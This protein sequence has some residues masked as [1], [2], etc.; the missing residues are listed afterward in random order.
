MELMG[1]NVLATP[2]SV[3]LSPTV[4]RR[5]APDAPHQ[6]QGT[7]RRCQEPRSHR[8]P[9]TAFSSILSALFPTATRIGTSPSRREEQLLLERWGPGTHSTHVLQNRAD[10]PRD[11][12]R[13]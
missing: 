7:R 9:G 6:Q 5:T 12:D 1:A 3:V 8:T 4:S 13:L 2:A 10:W 11:G